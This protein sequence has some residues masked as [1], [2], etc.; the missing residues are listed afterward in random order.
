M[1]REKEHGT[2]LEECEAAGG[3]RL[4][5]S[6]RFGLKVCVEEFLSRVFSYDFDNP[7]RKLS[8]YKEREILAEIRGYAKA[9][10]H[11]REIIALGGTDAIANLAEVRDE[12][13]MRPRMIGDMRTWVG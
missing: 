2:T 11:L 1:T 3:E 12:R 9:Q 4:P 13:Q 5:K 6:K 8:Q 10:E 7:P